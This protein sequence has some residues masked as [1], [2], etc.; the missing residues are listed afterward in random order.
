M[1]HR[2]EKYKMK[3]EKK[4]ETLTTNKR[5]CLTKLYIDN[6]VDG[7]AVYACL[8]PLCTRVLT[9]MTKIKPRL[10]FLEMIY[11]RQLFYRIKCLKIVNKT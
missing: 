6:N 8:P 5:N 2:T 9:K 7:W 3:N 4:H 11:F 10:K 1:P